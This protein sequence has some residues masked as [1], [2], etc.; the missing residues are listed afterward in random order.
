MDSL[1][2]PSTRLGKRVCEPMWSAM[3]WSM[4]MVFL[5]PASPGCFAEVSH[6]I[7]EVW[8][9]APFCSSCWSPEM[10]EKSFFKS[11]SGSRYGVSA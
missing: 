7:S 11:F 2:V 9:F 5:N 3:S 10:T 8:P 1:P 6:V 4:E